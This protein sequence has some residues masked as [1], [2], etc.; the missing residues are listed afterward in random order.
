MTNASDFDLEELMEKDKKI[1][2]YLCL[3]ARDETYF[4]LASLT[5][6]QISDQIDYLADEKYGG[7]CPR[8]WNF[9]IDEFGNF[10]KITNMK[11]QTSFGT[12]KGMR[13]IMA[14]QSFAQLDEKYGE[15]VSQII[16][17]NA[18]IKI[19]LRSPNEVTLEKISKMLGNYTTSSYSKS[20]NRPSGSLSQKGTDG[21]SA[22]LVGRPLLFPD[23]IG[24]LQRPYSLVMSDSDP[25]IMYAPD[26]SQYTWNEFF[27]LGDEKHNTKL[28]QRK[29]EEH[30]KKERSHNQKMQLWGIWDVWQ[31][32]IDAEIVR[33]QLEKAAKA[34]AKENN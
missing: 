3:P 8:R 25:A 27:G 17:D 21:E 7:R 34:A 14:I 19:Y 2:I 13:D 24:D 9:V 31:Q 6:R 15:K 1:I 18:D 22:N 11:Q 32:H 28:R 29:A 12:G 23:E 4:P 33:Q 30:R 10:T 26:L 20:N 5:L 16:Q